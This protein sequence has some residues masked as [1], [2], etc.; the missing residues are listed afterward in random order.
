MDRRVFVVNRGPHNYEDAAA[1][2]DLVYCTKGSLPK[3][4][5]ALMYRELEGPLAD[6]IPED[7]ILLTSLTSL[8]S[9]ACAIFAHMHGRL[10]LLLFSDGRYIPKSITFDNLNAQ[11]HN[12]GNEAQGKVHRT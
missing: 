11:G 5:I 4:D 8:C 3:D 9:V 1:F 12:D 2:G 6:S 10:N 7:F